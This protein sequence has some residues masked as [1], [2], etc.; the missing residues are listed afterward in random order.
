L[1][2]RV[3]SREFVKQSIKRGARIR[4]TL[5]VVVNGQAGQQTPFG[6]IGVVARVDADAT[7]TGDAIEQWQHALKT[8]GLC[9]GDLIGAYR[10]GRRAV[11][12]PGG[13]RNA[14]NLSH[15]VL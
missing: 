5:A 3:R 11:R 6:V 10:Y 4:N 7:K 1:T 8:R 13:D 2:Y 9:E 12:F 14:L 15:H